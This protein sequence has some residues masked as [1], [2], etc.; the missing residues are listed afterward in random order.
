MKL[1]WRDS[2][3]V[4]C[5]ACDEQVVRDDAR[6]YDTFGDRWD[7]D[8]KRVES[9]CKP[10]NRLQCRHSRDGVESRLVAAGAGEVSRSTFV[11]RLTALQEANDGRVRE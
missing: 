10:C 7:R 1:P 6:E 5:I 9:L 2:E 8:E 11:A 4:R 3:T